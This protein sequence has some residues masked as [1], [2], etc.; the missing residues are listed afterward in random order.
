MSE[1]LDS[2]R[3]SP[4][5]QRQAFFGSLVLLAGGIIALLVVVVFPSS[6]HRLNAPISNVPAQTVKNDP[7][8]KVDPKAVAIAREFLLTAVQRKNLDW[9]YDNVHV[10][11]RGRMSRAEWDKGNIPV[12]PCDAQNA[13]TTAFIPS[14]SLREEVEF[15]VTLI[16]NAHSQFCGD[17]PVRFFIA[18]RRE[19]NSP[20]GRWL[21]SYWEPHWKPPLPL[22]N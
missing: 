15:D 12:V 16:P 2:F 1:V 8:A 17:R 22:T 11:L 6:S 20:T 21:V 9:A 5:R 19:H 14:F 3:N 10:D 18:L 7:P 13:K 4:R